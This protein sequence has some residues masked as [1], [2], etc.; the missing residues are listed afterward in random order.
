MAQTVTMRC[1]ERNILIADQ[2]LVADHF[3]SRLKGLLG[4]SALAPGS[5]LWL[6]PC[7]AVHTLGMKFAI[8]VVFLDGRGRVVGWREDLKPGQFARVKGAKS[9]VEL[10]SGWLRQKNIHCGEHWEIGRKDT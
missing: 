5:G 1:V 9:V 3:F 7:D 8:D 6:I 10:P 2:V 4:R